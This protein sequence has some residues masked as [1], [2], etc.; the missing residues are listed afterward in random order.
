MNTVDT[1]FT[2]VFAVGL[3]LA[4]LYHTIVVVL[5]LRNRA[6]QWTNLAQL[7]VLYSK[8]SGRAA[9]IVLALC[10]VQAAFCYWI[11]LPKFALATMLSGVL[12]L[13]FQISLYMTNSKLQRMELVSGN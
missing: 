6:G 13:V 11:G 2:N 12:A 5:A 9:L 7:T 1:L 4:V 10:V 8:I 3:L